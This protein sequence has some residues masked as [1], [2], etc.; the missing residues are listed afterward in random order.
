MKDQIDQLL[1]LYER[2]EL[3]RR[4]VVEAVAALCAAAGAVGPASAQ[5]S[6]APLVKARTFNHVSLM[7]KDLARSKA[8]YSRLTGLPVRSEAPGNFC[9]FRLEN[10]FLG[11]YSQTFM[12]S[13]APKGDPAERPG[14]NHVCFG[15]ESYDMRRLEGELKLAIPEAKPAVKYGSELYAYDPDGVK[16][17]FADVNYKR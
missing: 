9:E 6:S 17:Q 3:S 1:S 2:R 10:G 12:D 14:F 5:P 15:V 7:T 8:F 4:G 13:I 16:L 11:L